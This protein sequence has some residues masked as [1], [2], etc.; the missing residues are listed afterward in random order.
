MWEERR[1]RLRVHSNYI[2]TFASPRRRPEAAIKNDVSSDPLFRDTPITRTEVGLTPSASGC[3][4]Q[5]FLPG[6]RFEAKLHRKRAATASSAHPPN[7]VG[8][9]CGGL[10]APKTERRG[11]C[12]D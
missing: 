5:L 11:G 3:W 4:P 6:V 9:S 8:V 12:R 1:L 10:H 2:L 7:V